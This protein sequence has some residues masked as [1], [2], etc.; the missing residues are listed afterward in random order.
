MLNIHVRLPS[1]CLT[2]PSD[3]LPLYAGLLAPR[4]MAAR[5]WRKQGSPVR[6]RDRAVFDNS[7]PT[8]RSWRQPA[9][10]Y[11]RTA[12]RLLRPFSRSGSA[13]E[14]QELSSHLYQRN[15]KWPAR[16]FS[17]LRPLLF[18][19]RGKCSFPRGLIALIALFAQS[20]FSC[21]VTG[22]PLAATTHVGCAQNA[23]LTGPC[24]EWTVTAASGA[25]RKVRKHRKQ[26]VD[27]QQESDELREGKWVIS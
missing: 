26:E 9:L 12:P 7:A 14:V 2:T 13:G 4:A 24:I 15:C 16:R 1:R 8:T 23:G 5:L 10:A 20:F 25:A 11:R 21:S 3:S 27:F 18:R 19:W 6:A 22:K 17:A